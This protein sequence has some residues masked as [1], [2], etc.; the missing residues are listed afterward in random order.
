MAAHE[1]FEM[2]KQALLA[3]AIGIP[4]VFLVLAIFYGLLKLLMLRSN[5]DSTQSEE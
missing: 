1:I 5:T 2:I 4:S 3:M